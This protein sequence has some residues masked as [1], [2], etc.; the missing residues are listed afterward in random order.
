MPENKDNLDLDLKFLDAEPENG[1]R[2]KDDGQSKPRAKKR[3]AKDA[4]Q[5]F[6]WKGVAIIAAIIIAIFAVSRNNNNSASR[7]PV[8]GSSSSTP[9]ISRQVTPPA[10]DDSVIVGSFRC[11]RSA[12]SQADRLRPA[13][14]T[15]LKT[16][17]TA[18][19]ARWEALRKFRTRIDALKPSPYSQQSAINLFNTLVDQYNSELAALQGESS[20]LEAKVDQFNN[21][22]ATYNNYLTSNCTRATR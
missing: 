8:S 10:Y 14:L 4:P 12:S 11:S 1:R 16:E 19:N 6:S 2:K 3:K 22:V 5:R 21:Q 17:Q 20:R 7:G 13:S 18:M 9:A 15:V